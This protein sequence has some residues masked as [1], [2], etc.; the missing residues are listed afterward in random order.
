MSLARSATV[1]SKYE[2][3]IEG[4]RRFRGV[5]VGEVEELDLRCGVEGEAEI[6]G[7]VEGPAQDVTGIALEG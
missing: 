1:S 4:H 6:V 3:E 7:P 2:P 5:A